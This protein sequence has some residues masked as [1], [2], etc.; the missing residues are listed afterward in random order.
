MEMALP[1]LEEVWSEK[2]AFEMGL[3]RQQKQ[4]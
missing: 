2:L 3:E 4:T 1:V